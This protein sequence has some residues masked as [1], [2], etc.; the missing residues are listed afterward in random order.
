MTAANG[1]EIEL[2]SIK[3]NPIALNSIKP[4]QTDSIEFVANLFRFHY[5]SIHGGFDRSIFVDIVLGYNHWNMIFN[6]PFLSQLFVPY[7]L[8]A[9]IFKALLG[10]KLAGF[11]IQPCSVN[12]PVYF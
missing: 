9:A 5:P 2:N 11:R 8:P 12:G 7:P 4:I 6:A 10:A 3:S 1:N